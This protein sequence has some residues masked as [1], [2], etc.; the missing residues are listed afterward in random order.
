MGAMVEVNEIK[1]G[2]DNVL[3]LTDISG[4]GRNSFLGYT[5][6]SGLARTRGYYIASGAPRAN[7]LYGSVTV[8]YPR[9]RP[10]AIYSGEQFGSYFGYA[11]ATVD[12]NGDGF[13]ELLVGAPWHTQE[14]SSSNSYDTGCVLIFDLQLRSRKAIEKVGESH[15]F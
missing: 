15:Y 12:L 2:K 14:F 4:I 8:S 3:I 7:G 6:T 13:D 5:V 10:F 11:L 9:H 1:P